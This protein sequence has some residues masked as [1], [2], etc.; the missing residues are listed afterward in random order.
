MRGPVL[1]VL[2]SVMGPYLPVSGFHASHCSGV[3]AR[4]RG[5]ET[6][7]TRLRLAGM[8]TSIT[9]SDRAPPASSASPEPMFALAPA[10]ESRPTTKKF[11]SPYCA[12]GSTMSAESGSSAL[13]VLRWLFFEVLQCQAPPVRTRASTANSADS[14]RPASSIGWCRRDFV[15]FVWVG[16]SAASADSAPES[17]SRAAQPC[18]SLV[19]SSRLGS[20]ER[21][22]HE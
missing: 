7:T 18:L 22:W 14:E 20:S 13:T 3:I 5:N 19:N 2:G 16:A 9:L 10:R 15:C 1:P 21:S 12:L 17:N 4:S 8:L 6:A 11:S